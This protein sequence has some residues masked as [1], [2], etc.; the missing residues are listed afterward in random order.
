MGVFMDPFALQLAVIEHNI[1]ILL[2]FLASNF[3]WPGFGEAYMQKK[4][5]RSGFFVFIA[6]ALNRLMAFGSV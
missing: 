4:S 3:K 1:N 5:H 6:L 2:L